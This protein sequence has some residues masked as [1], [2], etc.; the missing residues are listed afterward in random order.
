[1]KILMT[2]ESNYPP[3]KRVENEIEALISAGHEID[4]I[5]F[6]SRGQPSREEYHGATVIRIFPC[7]ITR[8]SSVG[9]LKVSV[10]FSYWKR[11]IRK[12][13]EQ[14]EYD[15][16]H[17]HDL[18]L[19]K[20]VTDMK[21]RFNFKTVLD[22][23]ENWPGLLSVSPYTKTLA[24]RILCN[25]A[26][27]EKYEKVYIRYADRVIVVIEEAKKRISPFTGDPGK[28]TIVSN[29]INTTEFDRQE[30][31][32]SDRGEKVVFIY[33]GGITYHRGLQ[34]IISALARTGTSNNDFELRIIGKG[35]YLPLL[36]RLVQ[37][38][39]LNQKVIFCGWK[40]I[41]EVYKMLGEAD[42]ALIP[43]LKSSHSDN[44]IP[45]L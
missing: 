44:T 4:I 35:S 2:L 5:C 14:N 26:D 17:I 10:Y 32:R 43:H 38:L 7:R 33:E 36:R 20:P 21:E 23:H 16:V 27:W 6:G 31:N 39:G 25:I 42:V 19:A 28:I 9:A 34:N 1:M 11:K 12:L 15:A 18:P 40:P 22:L 30:I 13:L 45:Q 37:D 29:T 41:G 3:D 24:G 8:K